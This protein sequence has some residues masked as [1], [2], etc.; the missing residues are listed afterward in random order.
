MLRPDFQAA[1]LSTPS[2]R[3]TDPLW[4]EGAGAGKPAFILGGA[5]GLDDAPG[6]AAANGHIVIGTN[7]TL[8]LL[9]PSIW[10]VV[11]A[12]VW[13]EES[14]RLASIPTTMAVVVNAAMFGGGI[15]S[16]AHARKARMI[17]RGERRISGINITPAKAGKRMRSGAMHYPPVTPFL[18]KRITEPFHPGSNSLCYA[19]QLAHLM[20]CAPI[21]AVGFTLQDG[22]GYH[23]GRT[24]PVTNRTSTYGDNQRERVLDWLRWH[25]ATFPDRVLLD[26]TFSGPVYD[27]LPRITADALQALARSSPADVGGLQPVA[28]DSCAAQAERPNR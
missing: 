7:W 16:T 27:V 14:H 6:L 22:L 1:L 11:D 19:I 9:I 20:G 28:D 23:F 13:K 2:G 25:V 10:L 5:G 17:G 18:P 15:Y 8:R 24:N 4:L 26:P 21:V 3:G 12:A